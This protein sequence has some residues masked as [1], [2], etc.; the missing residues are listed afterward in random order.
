MTQKIN[1]N[2]EV[3]IESERERERE[4]MHM[5]VMKPAIIVIYEGLFKALTQWR[6]TSKSALILLQ[7]N[8]IYYLNIL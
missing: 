3:I 7:V 1:S 8:M 2:I 4:S 5:E 6:K